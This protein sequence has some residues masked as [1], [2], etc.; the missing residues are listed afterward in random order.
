MYIEKLTVCFNFQD[1][2]ADSM[3]SVLQT[4]AWLKMRST[5]FLIIKQNFNC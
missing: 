2:A 5:T 1:V 3:T 4:K